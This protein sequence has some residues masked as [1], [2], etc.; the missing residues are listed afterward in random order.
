MIIEATNRK[1]WNGILKKIKLDDIFFSNNF[2][3]FHNNAKLFLY[4]KYNNIALFSFVIKKDIMLSFRYGGI[5]TNSD[6]GDFVKETRSR[7]MKYCEAQNVKKAQIRNNPFIKTIKIGEI[8]K[9]EPFVY[10]ALQKSERQLK[11][12]ISESHR[13]CIKKAMEEG[14]LF[15]ETNALKYLRIFYG[16]YNTILIEKG[17]TPQKF[18]YF[19]KMFFYLKDNLKLIYIKYKEEIIAVSIIL[20]SNNNVFMMYGGMNESGYKKY[21]KHFMIYKLIFEYKRKGYKR[22]IL[23]TGNNGRDSIYQFKRGFTNK[24]HYIYTYG[25]DL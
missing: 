10:I 13:K 22:L 2:G 19:A 8:I 16:F 9:K 6:K 5:L 7:F 18:S 14:L 23:G 20:E 11:E 25:K 24:D 4:Q 21:A 17:I 3:K 15:K 1:L 12:E